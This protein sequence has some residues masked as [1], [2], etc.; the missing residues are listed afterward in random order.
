MHVFRNWRTAA[1]LGSALLSVVALGEPRLAP[2]ATSPGSTKTLP[3]HIAG[4]IAA[5]G[6]YQWPGL[7]FESKFK[8][9]SVYFKIGPGDVILHVLV[10]GKSIGTLVKPA[11]GSYLIDG[12]TDGEHTVRINSVTESQSAPN[13]FGGFP[14]PAGVKKLAMAPRKRQIE[15]IGDSHTVGYGNTS[16]SRDCTN[17]EVWATTDNSQT[18]APK[19]AEHYGADYQVNAISGRGIVRNY[20]GSAGDPLPVAYPFVLLNHTARY[21]ATAWQPQIIVIALGT[22]DFSTPLKAGE[23]WRTRDELHADFEATYVK[24]VEDLRAR[25]P[26]AFIIL[27]A[28]DMAE[29]EIAQEAGK[30]AAQLQ[31]TGDNRVAFI[32]IDGLEMTGCHWHPSLAD[33]D[34]I[35]EKLIRF[36]DERHL[37]SARR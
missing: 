36:I 33:E 31:S 7:Y 27:W 3:A 26:H 25:N 22:N 21:V 4:R 19:I 35:A 24:F 20:D 23:K 29:H 6:A 32:A 14:L 18:F 11:A 2:I 9:R 37:A 13:T 10:D 12:L 1:W 16:K 28:T 15:F 30:V 17:D 5:G 34:K 8:G